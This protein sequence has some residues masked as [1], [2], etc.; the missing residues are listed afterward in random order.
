VSWF[1]KVL[2]LATALVQL[3]RP[4]REKPGPDV[5]AIEPRDLKQR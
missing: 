5:K 4:K 1:G 3:I 2:D